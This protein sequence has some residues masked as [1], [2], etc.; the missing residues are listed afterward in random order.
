MADLGYEEGARD[1]SRVIEAAAS[2]GGRLVTADGRTL[3]LSGVSVRAEAAGGLARVELEQ[4]FV[5]SYAEPLRVTYLVP[6]PTEGALAGYAIRVGGRRIVGEIDR[7][8]LARER[9]EKALVEGHSA[10]LVEQDRANLFTL[11]IGN[12]PPGAEL[13]AE[14]QIDQPLAW[15]PEGEWEWR[16]PLVVAPRYQGADGRVFDAGR[17]TVDVAEATFPARGTATVLVRDQ[18]ANGRAPESPS[19]ALRVTPDPS[20]PR[21]TLL[22]DATRDGGVAA[23]SEAALVEATVPVD[24][25]LVVGWAVGRSD[26]GVTLYTSRPAAD[27]PN[28]DAAYGLVTITPPAGVT[29]PWLARD[30][31]VLLDTSGSMAGQPLDQARRVVAG[32]V[33]S[34]TDGDHL[35]LIEFSN[36]ARRWRPGAAR[37]TASARQ[38]ALQWLGAIQARGGTEMLEGI[39]E[40]LGP[41][42]P[43]AQRQVVLVTD[44][45]VGF[46]KEI[47]SAVA[48]DLPAT[49]RLHAIAVGSA[50][51]R[52][53]TG[54]A[55]RAGRG[56]EVVID[57]DEKPEVAITRLLAHM[58][59]PLLTQVEVGGPAVLGHAPARLPDVFAGAP[60]RVAMKLRPEGGEIRVRGRAP[61]GPWEERIVVPAVACGEGSLAIATLYAR[62]AVED[63]E[64]QEAA[65]RVSAGEAEPEIERIGLAFQIATRRTAWVAVSEEPT[66]DPTAPIRRERIPHELP[67]GMSI[68]G[69]GLALP[70]LI[71]RESQAR[72]AFTARPD[73]RRE[74]VR[75]SRVPAAIR[76]MTAPYTEAAP[77]VLVA[78]STLRKDRQLALEIPVGEPVD[79]YA[80]EVRVIWEGGSDIGAAI[81]EGTTRPGPVDAGQVIRLV[82]LLE[83]DGP[84]EAPIRVELKSLARALHLSLRQ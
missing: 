83:K 19:H 41:L 33:E 3:P 18:L 24:R 48:R 28:A 22:G 9:F 27:Q 1:G 57:L 72:M 29:R 61:E 7:I 11:E 26:P 45:L 30:L 42:R 64:L 54:P 70:R 84:A 39:M 5:N 49:S 34:L 65:G 63:L 35:E 73:C 76:D 12:I 62:E 31:I 58:Q 8:A 40:A 20:G 51:N 75:Y 10:G 59:A 16:F 44:G 78:R 69:L 52:A 38:E 36:T 60:L 46:E 43:D 71:V 2:C 79:W 68:D 81:V 23:G 4:R 55:A 13:E 21:V 50:P 6:L 56:T 77:S 14:L 66:T 53:L 82:L 32:L 17:I 25:D 80:R 37:A 15:R 67:Y 74:T 47:V